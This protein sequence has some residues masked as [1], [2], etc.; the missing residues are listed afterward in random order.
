MFCTNCGAALPDDAKFC[1]SCG[2]PAPLL[3]DEEV[4]GSGEGAPVDVDVSALDEPTKLEDA[5]A[6]KRRGMRPAAIAAIAIAVVAV[7]VG[8]GA[9][10]WHCFFNAPA[11][12][13]TIERVDLEQPSTKDDATSGDADA[14]GGAQ[15]EGADAKGDAQAEGADAE[16]D[17]SISTGNGADAASADGTDSGSSLGASSSGG[18]DEPSSDASSSQDYILPNSSTEL[19]SE[20]DLEGLSD[21]ELY[22][23]RN[24]IYARHGRGFKNKDLQEYFGSKSWYVERYT[25]EEFDANPTLSDIELQNVETIHN[26]EKARGSSH[27]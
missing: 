8:G 21:W 6:P 9:L 24:E 23:A 3:G 1:T 22:I 14:E 15:A 5:S 12:E 4:A 26:V 13:S 2:A 18:A 19:I 17:D 20:Q 16:A 11:R 10:T 7:L 27:A 25:S